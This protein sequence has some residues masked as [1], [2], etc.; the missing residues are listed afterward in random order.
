MNYLNLNKIDEGIAG[1]DKRKNL[2]LTKEDIKKYD[3]LII[4]KINELVNHFNN[5]CSYIFSLD[6]DLNKFI[7]F[8]LQHNEDLSLEG[9][10][11]LIYR[12]LLNKT[13]SDLEII[14]RLGWQIMGT[15]VAKALIMMMGQ[16]GNELENTNFWKNYIH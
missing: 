11:I 10:Q 13:L 7:N 1:Q 4:N 16:I 5:E 6:L 15:S 12:S 9:V 2:Y 3:T 14:R 8:S